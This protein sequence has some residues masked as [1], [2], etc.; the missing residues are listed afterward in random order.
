MTWRDGVLA[1][2]DLEATGVDPHRD[3]I[4][5]AAVIAV[6]GGKPARVYECLVNP[7][8]PIPTAASDIHGITDEQA[9]RGTDLDFTAYE[10]AVALL[11][12]ARQGIPIIGHNV[13]YDL[14]MLRA[15]LLRADYKGHASSARL[16]GLAGLALAL[17]Q[18]RPVIDTLV[19]DK[20]L[21]PYRPKQP[22][23]RRPDP[24]TCGSRRL[25]DVARVYGVPLSEA[26]AHGA[27]ADALAA[28]RIAWKLGG[29]HRLPVDL[30]HL[31][32]F[33][34]AEKAKQA[35]ALQEWLHK[36]GKDEQISPQWPVQEPPPDWAPDQLPAPPETEKSVA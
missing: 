2:F 7:E 21:D 13:V 5:S 6:G 34:V 32:D 15:H 17:L 29:D 28:G 4:V 35:A 16:G 31:H 22:T 11:D 1:C 23:K 33:Q 10:V 30:R 36:Q 8:I 12:A 9:A 20:V 25:T 14:T 24:A 27:T 18:I 26:D 19:L 3:R